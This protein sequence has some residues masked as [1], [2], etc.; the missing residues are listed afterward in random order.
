MESLQT[1]LETLESA[2]RLFFQ[3]MKRPG[4]W[5][6]VT[7]RAGIVIDRPAA[8]VLKAVMICPPPCRV[9][10]L[11]EML[12]VEAPSITRKTQ[13]LERAGYLRRVQDKRDR[14][15]TDLHITA[16]GRSV[17]NRLWNAQQEI[18][19]EILQNWDPAERRQFVE[20]FQRFGNEL[21]ASMPGAQQQHTARRGDARV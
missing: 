3:T 16:R 10:N 21:A 15:A 13:E 20:S 17:A 6:R 5:S 19:S 9:Q 8:G 12:G 2:M 11:A 7:A 1:D 14:R 4:H 18:I